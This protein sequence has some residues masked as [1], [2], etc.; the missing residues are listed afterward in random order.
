MPILVKI[1][2]AG[3][4]TAC[5]LNTLFFPSSATP[6]VL[7][8]TIASTIMWAFST[9][10]KSPTARAGLYWYVGFAAFL[11]IICIVLGTSAE[12]KS[13][14]DDAT[15]YIYVFYQ[16]AALIGGKQFNYLVFAGFMAFSVV[17]LMIFDII[18]GINGINSRECSL[19][20]YIAS[21]VARCG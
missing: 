1:V 16:N 2:I 21:K 3:V 4:N 9:K 7:L 18:A 8:T 12:I 20:S 17:A 19:P 14:A 10:E 11:S 13:A 6:F 5:L 15:K